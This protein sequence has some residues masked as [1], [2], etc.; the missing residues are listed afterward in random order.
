MYIM[1]PSAVKRENRR[2]LRRQQTFRKAADVVTDALVDFEEVEAVAVVGSAARALWKERPRSWK[3]RKAGISLW[4]ECRDLDLAVWLSS[5]ERLKGLR[6]ARD[7]A[8]RDARVESG[9]LGMAGNQVELLLLEPGSDRYLGRLCDFSS[10]PKR[11]QECAVPGCGTVPFKRVISGFFRLDHLLEPTVYSMLYR[12]GEGRLMSA[13][14]LPQPET[15]SMR[16][17]RLEKE[18]LDAAQARAQEEE[19]EEYPSLDRILSCRS[20]EELEELL[21]GYDDEPMIP[22]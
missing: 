8:L 3:A 21:R 15:S 10:C 18:R 14:D 1:P 22:F 2:R 13:L 4:H 12:R 20:D 9:K 17:R 7:I 6:R 5:L 19:E 11:K 16:H